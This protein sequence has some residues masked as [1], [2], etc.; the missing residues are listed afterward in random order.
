[1]DKEKGQTAAAATTTANCRTRN[2]LPNR[3][4]EPLYLLIGKKLSIS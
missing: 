1:V 2:P 3:M 4:M